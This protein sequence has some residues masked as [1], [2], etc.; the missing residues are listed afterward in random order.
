MIT[1]AMMC[2]MSA[3]YFEARGES[4]EGR[5]AVAN[6]V[7]NRSINQNISPCRVVSQ[8]NQFSWYKKALQLPK[9]EIPEM[10]R[11]LEETVDSPDNTKGSL[12]FHNL[13]VKPGWSKK[14]VS[15]VRY[16]K[17]KFYRSKDVGV[18]DNKDRR[19]ALHKYS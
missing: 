11:L 17:H 7:I 4:E 3:M 9:S 10:K 16:G 6:V 14:S 19:N 15:T 5:K 13:S 1:A 18:N 8:P 2:I 12:Y